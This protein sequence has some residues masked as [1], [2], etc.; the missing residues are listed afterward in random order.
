MLTCDKTT[1]EKEVRIPREEL[2]F[3]ERLD[4]VNKLTQVISH[5][6]KIMND[7]I[8]PPTNDQTRIKG[9]ARHLHQK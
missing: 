9:T 1:T 6:S 4:V 7:L 2:R 5:S 3:M 8:F